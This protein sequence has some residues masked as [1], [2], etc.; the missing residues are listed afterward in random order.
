MEQSIERHGILVII[1]FGAMIVAG[2]M[3][4]GIAHDDRVLFLVGLV[5]AVVALASGFA[6]Y[7]DH[8]RL[9]GVLAAITIV[10]VSS[11]IVRLVS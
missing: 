8:P 3:A 11:S 4:Y 9:Y 7:L 1:V 2:I 6:I 10:L 5:S